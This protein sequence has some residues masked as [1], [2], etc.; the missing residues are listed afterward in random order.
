MPQ[1]LFTRKRVLHLLLAT[2]TLVC[3]F[4]FYAP[5]AHG[6]PV[7]QANVPASE[8]LLDSGT[9]QR[10]WMSLPESRIVVNPYNFYNDHSAM[11]P[12]AYST[13]PQLP[14]NVG[15][16]TGEAPAELPGLL[17]L[18]YKRDAGG[19]IVNVV[20]ETFDDIDQLRMNWRT[21]RSLDVSLVEDGLA[22]TIKD[23][24]PET[25]G[26]VR[27]KVTLNLDETPF[28]ELDVHSVA[29]GAAWALKI[30]DGTL[31]VDLAI[32]NNITESGRFL[33]DIRQ[34]SGWSGVKTF[35]II[36]FTINA[37][38][39]LSEMNVLG[40]R[41]QFSSSNLFTTSWTPHQIDYEARYPD[42]V[43]VHSVDSFYD[44]NTLTRTIRFTEITEDSEVEPSPAPTRE[45]GFSEDFDDAA[46]FAANWSKQPN[47][48][49]D[50]QNGS[51]TLR[52]DGSSV[53][54]G[55]IRRPV[56]VDLDA[57]PYIEIDVE[58]VATEWSIKVSDGQ[59]GETTI[60]AEGVSGTK[61]Y[62]LADITGWSGEQT[63]DLILYTVGEPAQSATR[64]GKVE[65]TNGIEPDVQAP[66]GPGKPVP[67][68]WGVE[69]KTFSISGQF[70]NSLHWDA[71][72]RALSIQGADFTFAISLGG[73]FPVA[74][75]QYANKISMLA[76]IS[77]TESL[78]GGYWSLD[79]PLDSLDQLTID[80]S[81][82]F[83]AGAGTQLTSIARAK[84]PIQLN[85]V[86]EQRTARETYWDGYLAS[87]PH[88]RSF[89]LERVDNLGVTPEQIY[90][91]YYRAWVFMAANILPSMPESA[92]PYPQFAAGKPSLWH[93]GAKEAKYAAAWE[94]FLAMQL[95]AYVNP[96]LAW[97]GFK[98]L[99]SLVDAN[100]MLGGESLPSRKAETAMILYQLT[101][102]KQSLMD[103]Y[104]GL[105]RYLEWRVKN[106]RWIYVQGGRDDP[107]ERDADFAFSAL[108]DLRHM[109]DIAEVLNKPD[110]VEHWETIR[111]QFYE[112][113]LEWFWPAPT[114]LP[115]Q[116]FFLN[117]GTRVA[118][119]PL[120]VAQ[121][122]YV[123]L[124]SGDYLASMM[125]RFR[126]AYDPNKTFANMNY[127]KYPNISFLTYGLL[128]KGY[129]EEAQVITETSIRDVV[130]SGTFSEQYDV[131][132]FPVPTGVR[133]SVFGAGML[134][135]SVLLKNGYKLDNGSPEFVNMFGSSGGVDNLNIR[136]RLLSFELDGES[137]QV[138]ISGNLLDA[139][140]ALEVGYGEIVPIGVELP[141]DRLPDAPYILLDEAMPTNRDVTV[142]LIHPDAAHVTLQYRFQ[143]ESAW[144]TY[145]GPFTV[146][147]NTLIYARA[148]DSG[149]FASIV[150]QAAI[151]NIDRIAPAGQIIY[152]PVGSTA[153]A[154][155][156]VL[157]TSE[158]VRVTN[159]GGSF[160]YRFTANGSFT[161]QFVDAAGNSG[162]AKA[163]VSSLP[164]GTGSSGEG[165]GYI[166]PVV[167]K[168]KPE[169]AASVVT[170]D[171][172]RVVR[173]PTEGAYE[174]EVA[175]PDDATVADI[176]I[177]V[178]VMQD[179]LS[180]PNRQ[181]T[182]KT[183]LA[184]LT[185]N[186]EW[187]RTMA[188]NEDQTFRLSIRQAS[189]DGVTIEQ[190]VDGAILPA[191]ATGAYLTVQVP[192][193]L[194]A[195]QLAHQQVVYATDEQGKQKVVQGYYDA[196]TGQMAFR[197]Q[198]SG[199]YVFKNNAVLFNDIAGVSWAKTGI[200]A[201]AAR[202]AVSGV[203]GGKFKPEQAVSRAELIHMLMEAMQTA[204]P[205]AVSTFS[206]V[207]EKAW[208]YRSVASAQRLGIVNGL[209]DGSFGVGNAVTRQDT[210][211]MLVRLMEQL[212]IEPQSSA[213]RQV[214][215]FNDKA[216]IS[217]YA[218]GAVTALQ[219]YGMLKGKNGNRFAPD[220]TL[221][222][223]EAAVLIYNLYQLR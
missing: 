15:Y 105:K 27:R 211:V 190:L 202:G 152:S 144:T 68:P 88:P 160:R 130:R 122:L 178:K 163:T 28:I 196:D 84:M 179:L 191:L 221:S 86:A 83:T 170:V 98:G 199:S 127:P 7:S 55:S 30:N 101:G 219:Q 176:D 159:N 80:I 72:E 66:E 174:F 195:G 217:G 94:S 45:V 10:R 207:S 106:P 75:S 100:G 77:S 50:I 93:Y 204:D 184:D 54:W 71:A 34:F 64:F 115:S 205:Q 49:P 189:S 96:E 208:Y 155:D 209:N 153:G 18:Y 192:Y 36:I 32:A 140:L 198:A 113:S 200:E 22:M 177:P 48:L 16:M 120:W 61:K 194:R 9:D 218:Q 206:D 193:A 213:Q 6:S 8:D 149:Q 197:M 82:A 141:G 2:V 110:D 187:Y 172:Q 39:V 162:S 138:R 220:D 142:E 89:E 148:L 183:R 124:L 103:V 37:Q 134:I 97:A 117:N 42:G 92:Y 59:G 121:G 188:L 166:P 111:Q 114:S 31:P 119:H 180:S 102:D 147:S 126:A 161:F 169:Q 164:G 57:T 203:G 186:S 165:G 51:L 129:T 125:N 150:R 99:I 133:P 74:L 151:D 53:P 23:A 167:Q 11:N 222:R 29:P 210:A 1:L 118:G 38:T 60:G 214:E 24:A 44:E 107:N 26:A 73:S 104:P 67:G 185:I 78:N 109:R 212:G 116:Y 4:D 5:M 76:G 85:N 132:S 143:G 223:A 139:P 173:G 19:G 12:Y 79:I 14:L 35:D 20:H 216:A 131:G 181:L 146:A 157:I 21:D 95:Y 40:V 13:A 41:E 87:V 154:V 33:Y 137:E 47:V 62:N 58:A 182:L 201:L 108:I 70:T 156:A 91:D 43:G 136:N 171:A 90:R 158:T 215:P 168:P 112:D 81:V 135:N 69:G 3:S 63:F 123:D 65:F 17:E 175:V 52:L 25:W 128:E 46:A 56:T 145:T